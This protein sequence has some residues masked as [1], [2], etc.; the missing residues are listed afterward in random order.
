[1][2]LSLLEFTTHLLIYLALVQNCPSTFSVSS[3][4]CPAKILLALFGSSTFD[5][6]QSFRRLYLRFQGQPSIHLPYLHSYAR[7]ALFALSKSWSSIC[8]HRKREPK[9]IQVD[10]RRENR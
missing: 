10:S 1:M 6:S 3:K 4:I 7:L 2:S 9:D 5:Q 8:L